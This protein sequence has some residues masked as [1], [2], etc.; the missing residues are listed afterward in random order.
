MVTSFLAFI[1]TTLW[2]NER[3]S[4]VLKWVFLSGPMYSAIFACRSRHF[5]AAMCYSQFLFAEPSPL[6]CS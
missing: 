6:P 3:R 2:F 1:L 4:S 5:K